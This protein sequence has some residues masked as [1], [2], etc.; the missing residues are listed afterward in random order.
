[1][2][3]NKS[4]KIYLL[5]LRVKLKTDSPYIR[6]WHMIS[7]TIITGAWCGMWSKLAGGIVVATRAVV[8]TVV[9]LVSGRSVMCTVVMRS[10]APPPC[11]VIENI[12][13]RARTSWSW[14]MSKSCTKLRGSRVMIPATVWSDRVCVTVAIMAALILV[15]VPWM[16][17]T[18]RTLPTTTA[19]LSS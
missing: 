10:A 7:H 8:S 2:S 4:V 15:P 6:G 3:H 5:G 9:G 11:L 18:R 16:C 17:R 14:C 12:V 19:L 1:M 13:L